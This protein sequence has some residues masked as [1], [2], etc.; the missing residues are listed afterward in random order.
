MTGLNEI[1]SKVLNNENESVPDQ[2][3]TMSEHSFSES[4]EDF[5]IDEEAVELA[6]SAKDF[7]VFH[8]ENY[9]S[10]PVEIFEQVAE[11]TPI[12]A[13]PITNPVELKFEQKSVKKSENVDSI[14]SRL[15]NMTAKNSSFSGIKAIQ[16]KP[17]LNLSNLFQSPVIAPID[18]APVNANS[19]EGK[20]ALLARKERDS[21]ARARDLCIINPGNITTHLENWPVSKN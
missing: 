9:S 10:A 15:K 1:I 16:E 13:I 20:M 7:D 19:Y 8:E 14:Q 17:A 6:K 11:K 5:E 2:D 18:R 3:Q 21:K 4:N 12:S